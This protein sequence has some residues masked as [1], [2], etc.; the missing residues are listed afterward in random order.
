[1]ADR[2]EKF[3]AVLLGAGQANNPL[4]RSLARAGRRVAL[5]EKGKIGGTC[6]NVGC[7]PTKTM[8]ASAR[9]AH[10]ARRAR[11]FG[12][13]TGPVAV[14]LQEVRARTGA[15]VEEFSAGSERQLEEAEGVELIRGEGWFTGPRTVRVELNGGGVRELS[16]ELVVI[17]V[18]CRPA[19]PEIPGL[20]S[21]PWLDS[22][23][24]LG[25]EATPDH[26]LV[27]GGGYIG[28]EFAQMFRRFGSR[29]TLVQKGGQLLRRED[30]DMAE[31]LAEILREDG[32]EVILDAKA[33]RVAGS[34]Q[35]IRLTVEVDG[36]SRELTASH[37]MVATGRTPNTESLNLTAAGVRTDDRGFI[38][39]DVR[40]ETNVPGVYA[41]GDVNG[42]PAFT[43]VSH[44]DNQILRENLLHDAGR[45][46][47]GRLVPFT[48]FT[49]P[50]F[51][52]VGL[53]EKEAR[54]R[55]RRV[56]IARLPMSQ[57]ARALEIGES[58]GILKAVV[59]A[60][61]D[62]I[63]GCTA[64]AVEGGEIMS[65]VQLAMMGGLPYQRLRDDMFSHPT[66][67]RGLNNL[68]AHL[69]E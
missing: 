7:T 59:D 65:M 26:L 24:I 61:T 23:R 46:T 53:T 48:V 16:G 13:H 39:V 69:E 30:P 44:N 55:G 9:V 34:A 18:G 5:I 29:V 14:R 35:E 66:L 12:V 2:P 38:P 21:A 33:T 45:T 52:R 28:V 41:L 19:R 54:E 60:E 68:F 27:L 47:A 32:V 6:V 56:R 51:G 1:M 25:L 10:L 43:H 57:V 64:L 42:G 11:D 31:A 36:R 22:T 62:L 50:Q 49:D 40:L 63:L 8:A 3:D 37:L 20:D 67:A 4:S 15:I 17:D 58:R